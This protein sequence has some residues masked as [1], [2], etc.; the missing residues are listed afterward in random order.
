MP[1][2]ALTHGRVG[3]GRKGYGRFETFTVTQSQASAINS[4]KGVANNGPV[5]VQKNKI[6][7]ANQQPPRYYTRSRLQINMLMGPNALGAAVDG[8]G[9]STYSAG[10]G[11]GFPNATPQTSVGSTNKFSR[12][13][14]A[15][16]A[17]TKLPG[18]TGLN[19]V[20]KNCCNPKQVKNM[21]GQFLI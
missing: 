13:A 17:V 5:T 2:R 4:S 19:G 18:T 7:L 3:G 11:K 20:S 12:R 9:V 8:N 16:R 6:N 10:E 14:I 21:K 15:R 1:Y